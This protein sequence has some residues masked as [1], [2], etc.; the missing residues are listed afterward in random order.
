VTA[1]AGNAVTGWNDQ[2]G[3]NN[4]ASQWD[5]AM[6]PLLVPNAVNGKPALR[7]DGAS[8]YLEVPD[9]PSATVTGDL[10]TFYVVRFDDFGTTARSGPRRSATC[11]ALRLLVCPGHGRPNAFRG[12][13]AGYG[14]VAGAAGVPTG[15]YAIVGLD[16][17]GAT[18][19]HLS[20]RPAQWQR[21]HHGL[22]RRRQRGLAHRHPR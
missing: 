17:S 1:D 8:R 14:T 5:P 22:A 6:A 2:S 9:S 3:Q 4:H 11:R 13:A 15:L 16:A 21:A 18:L 19:T 20:Q 10:T 7:F 12:G